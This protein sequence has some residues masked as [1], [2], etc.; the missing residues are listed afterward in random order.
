MGPSRAR[1]RAGRGRDRRGARQAAL[2]RR[3][4]AICRQSGRGAGV[5]RAGL[6]ERAELRLG[7]CGPR[8]RPRAAHR[9]PAGGLCP[10][11]RLRVLRL[12]RRRRTGRDGAVGDRRAR[13]VGRHPH[14]ARRGLERQLPAQ[15]AGAHHRKARHRELGRG[16]VLGGAR[17]LGAR[18]AR[19]GCALA[20]RRRRARRAARRLAVS[21]HARTAG[22]PP[23]RRGSRERCA[24]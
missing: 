16:G 7:E 24:Q 12:A 6:L 8:A 3:R 11:R 10:A 5:G 9:R 18:G 14:G 21:R 4:T 20:V 15:R 22:V 2:Q 13:A 17:R 1:T 19:R 23:A